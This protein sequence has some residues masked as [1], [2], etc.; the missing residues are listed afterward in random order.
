MAHFGSYVL[1]AAVLAS[2]PCQRL[3]WAQGSPQWPPNSVTIKLP[4]P[5]VLPP[6]AL[7]HL[8]FSPNG[9]YVLAQD[10][11]R[12]TVLTVQPFMVIFGAPAENASLAEFSP[13]SREVLFVSSVTHAESDKLVLASSEPRVE[14]RNIAERKRVAFTEVHSQPCGTL[15]LSPDGRILACVDFEGTLTLINVGSSKTIFEKKGFCRPFVSWFPF[16]GGWGP[17]P[18]PNVSGDL[19]SAGIAFSPD[20]RFVL[21]VPGFAVGSAVAWDLVAEHTVRLEGMLKLHFSHDHFALVA[22]GKVVIQR[23]KLTGVWGPKGTLTNTVVAFPSG[24]PLASATLPGGDLYRAADPEFV[25]LRPNAQPRPVDAVELRTGQAITS[26]AA[27]LDVF[28]NHYVT[29][30]ANGEL[31][32]YER[33]K[34]GAVAVVRLTALPRNP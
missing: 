18:R 28:G 14:R 22:P 2:L 16:N 33:G 7:R 34:A 32:L 21:V 29:E 10:S 19:G 30:R 1:T 3:A 17:V 8:R 25:L 27:A 12:V 23:T 6:G 4:G 9:Q 13:D 20:G 31:G 15:E 26:A 24:V 11:S 5:P